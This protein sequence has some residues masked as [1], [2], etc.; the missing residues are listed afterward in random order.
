MKEGTLAMMGGWL[1]MTKQVNILRMMRARFL[2]LQEE[3]TNMEK[4]KNRI[5]LLVLDSTL[6][7]ELVVFQ[8][9]MLSSSIKRTWE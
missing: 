8:I 2:L 6:I 9:D 4:E 3:I 5:S 7:H 1:Y